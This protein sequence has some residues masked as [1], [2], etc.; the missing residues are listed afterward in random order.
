MATGTLAT[1]GLLTDDATS[2]AAGALP[3]SQ[4][5]TLGAGKTLQADII[6]GVGGG[7]VALSGGVSGVPASMVR[8]QEA[9]GYGSSS[10]KI[11]RFVTTISST[12]SDVTYADSAT[13]GG[14]FTINTTGKY[15]ISYCDINGAA[16]SLGLSLNSAQLTTSVPAITAADRLVMSVA[17]AADTATAMSWTGDLTA[18]D[19]VRAHTDGAAASSAPDQATLTIVRLV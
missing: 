3:L 16:S 17:T 6:T 19:V 4:G 8:V 13:L 1:A 12:G 10:T 18:T 5:A 7:P 9:N 14:T 15:A 2:Q 11:R